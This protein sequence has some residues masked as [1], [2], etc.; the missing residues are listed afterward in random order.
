MC[1]LDR[2]NIEDKQDNHIW[3][4]EFSVTKNPALQAVST[5]T[6]KSFP[7]FQASHK[8]RGE[9]RVLWNTSSLILGTRK[10]SE[11]ANERRL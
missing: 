6:C 9:V 10:L 7:S 4:E 5:N 2:D 3:M 1:V 11:E 8:K